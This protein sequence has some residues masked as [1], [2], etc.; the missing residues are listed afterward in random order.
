MDTDKFK[1]RVVLVSGAWGSGTSAVAGALCCM[2]Y[3][4]LGPFYET[5]DIRTPNSFEFIGFRELILKLASEPKVKVTEKSEA[6]INREISIFKQRILN[7]E[8]GVFDP[9]KSPPLFFKFPLSALFIPELAA[10]FDVRLIVVTRP[11][12]EIENTRLRR[13]WPS[14]LGAKGARIIYAQIS[15]VIFKV[16]FPALF[17]PYPN[18]RSNPGPYIRMINHFCEYAPDDI[19]IASAISSITESQAGVLATSRARSG[20]EIKLEALEKSSLYTKLKFK[21]LD[22]L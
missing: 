7:Q 3:S 4:G 1:P 19:S 5:N 8:F 2:G 21:L 10:H 17:V 15:K 20:E 16:G 18:L 6:I 11:L 13:K 9:L 12:D 22:I 14:Y